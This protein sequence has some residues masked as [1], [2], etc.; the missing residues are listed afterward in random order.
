VQVNAAAQVAGGILLALGWFPRLAAILLAGSLVPTTLAGHRFWEID[1]P[2]DRARQRNQFLKN[3]GLLG[4]LILAAVD[5]EGR[6]SVTWRA[7]RAAKRAAERLPL[8][9]GS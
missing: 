8:P 3:L 4:G 5:T 2:A 6:P 7:K 9:I 1:D